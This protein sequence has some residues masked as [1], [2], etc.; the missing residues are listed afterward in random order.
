MSPYVYERTVR[1][2]PVWRCRCAAAS[3]PAGGPSLRRR[4]V[5][6][7]F[8]TAAAAPAAAAAAAAGPRASRARASVS[9]TAGSG[10][11]AASPRPA[12]RPPTDRR[13]G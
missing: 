13:R 9:G 2:A 12:P 6:R 8:P 11:S 4:Q 5:A 3:T 10:A 7:E 1:R